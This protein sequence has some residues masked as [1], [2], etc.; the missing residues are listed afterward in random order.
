[1]LK[2]T[3]AIKDSVEPFSSRLEEKLNTISSSDPNIRKI[4][5][6]KGTPF[7]CGHVLLFVTKTC[8]KCQ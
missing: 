8:N 1:L 4:G 3:Y 5:I 2:N 7:S 6:R